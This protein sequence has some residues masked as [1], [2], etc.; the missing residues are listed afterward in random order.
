[1]HP[2][3]WIIALMAGVAVAI[4]GLIGEVTG[5]IPYGSGVVPWVFA[6]APVILMMIVIA[7]QT[8]TAERRRKVER[9]TASTAALG[10]PVH[11]RENDVRAVRETLL[12]LAVRSYAAERLSVTSLAECTGS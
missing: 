2:P 11:A 9:R 1:M 10:V 6:M 7:A 12:K 3:F 4:S 8:T 5:V